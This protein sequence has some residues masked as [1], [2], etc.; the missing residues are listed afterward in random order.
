MRSCGAG[1]TIEPEHINLTALQ[2][3]LSEGHGDHMRAF[4]HDL[5]LLGRFG[6]VDN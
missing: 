4:M 3:A 5:A 6:P 1:A 2:K